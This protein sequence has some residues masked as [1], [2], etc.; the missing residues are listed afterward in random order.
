MSTIVPSRLSILADEIRTEVAAA[1]ADFQSAVQ[2]AINAGNRLIEAKSLVRH[3][4][5]L[6]WL[7]A[8]FPGAQ[9]TARNYMRL[10]ANG[11]RVADLPTVRETLALLTAPKSETA[12]SEPRTYEEALRRT[13]AC[14]RK[15]AE[16]QIQFSEARDAGVHLA[17]GYSTWEQFLALSGCLEPPSDVRRDL[18]DVLP[19][20][21]RLIWDA[22]TTHLS[23]EERDAAGLR[24]ELEAACGAFRASI[25]DREIQAVVEDPD[26][27]LRAKVELLVEA[28]RLA[29]E[30][31]LIAAELEVDA[32]RGLGVVLKGE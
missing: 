16:V 17:Q 32:A 28:E 6:P 15:L 20:L 4:E 1:E 3:G 2:H 12:T 31:R 11:Q 8:N 30:S 27:D 23:A 18:E 13:G 10:A 7:E 25:S 24:L 9:T 5:W 22:V 14:S 26:L 21:Q 19:A 29:T